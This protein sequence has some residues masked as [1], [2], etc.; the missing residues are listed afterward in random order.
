[1]EPL[2]IPRLNWEAYLGNSAV[3]AAYNDLKRLTSRTIALHSRS[4]VPTVPESFYCAWSVAIHIFIEE[5]S[6]RVNHST[7]HELLHGILVEEGYHK[8]AARLPTSVNQVLSNDLQH[9]EIFQRMEGYSLDMGPYWVHWEEQLRLG[10]DGMKSEVADPHVGFVHFPQLFTWFFFQR[11]SKPYLAEYRDVD[12][13]V[14][15][16][17]KAAYEDTRRIGFGDVKSQRQSVEIFKDHW[18]QYCDRHLPK[19]RFGLELAGRIRD[20]T[21]T[22]MIDFERVRSGAEII[23]LLQRNGLRHMEDDR[24]HGLP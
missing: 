14:Y 19:D 16:A 6:P 8:V 18:S 9:P 23:A 4:I 21:I 12:P 3:A 5:T 20:A 22:P 2:D 1:M 13:V 11:V 17:A 7:V 24:R 10:L 15:Q